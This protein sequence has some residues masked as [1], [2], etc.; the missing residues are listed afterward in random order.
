MEGKKNVRKK[1]KLNGRGAEIR[2]ERMGINKK[3]DSSIQ[4]FWM[5]GTGFLGAIVAAGLSDRMF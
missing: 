2:G 5:D 3:Q 4:H 1:R